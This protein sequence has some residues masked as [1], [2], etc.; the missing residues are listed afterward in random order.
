MPFAA[1]VAIVWALGTLLFIYIWP[2]I[3]YAAY[4]R[5]I[6]RY[7]LGGGPVPINTLYAASNLASSSAS[8]ASLL[9]TGTRDLL[10]FGG[11]LDLADGPQVLHVPDMGDRYFSIQFTDSRD[12]A[13]FAYVGTRSTGNRAGEYLISGPGWHGSAPQGVGKITSPN[14]AVLVIGRALVDNDDDVAAAFTLTKQ[15]QL[16]PLSK[17]DAGK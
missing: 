8:S 4:K 11:W 17:W 3:T 14:N 6:L 1:V 16:T 15:I 2:R 12:G 7:G 10:Y 5:A 9:A 13:N